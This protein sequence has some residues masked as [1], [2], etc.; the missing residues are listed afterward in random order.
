M[1]AQ[2]HFFHE[3]IWSIL[4]IVL[5]MSASTALACTRILWNTNGV[6]TVAGRTMDWAESTE[7]RLHVFP[8]GMHRNGGRVGPLDLGDENPLTWMSRYGS[9]VVSA[10][11]LASVDGLNEKGLAM[12]LLFLTA[13]DYGPRNPEKAGLQAGLW[14]QYLLDNAATVEEALERMKDVQPIMV[15]HAGFKSSLHL[16][17][18]DASG[19]SAIIEYVDGQPKIYHG[20]EHQVVTNDPPYDEQLIELEKWDFANATR[21]TPLP[22]NVNPIDRF[23]RANYF[24]KTL[25][26]P[27][28]E[29]EAIATTLS[30]ARNASVPFNA[31]YKTPGTIYDTEY[32]TVVNLDSRRFFFELTT[33]PNVIWVNLEDLALSPGSPVLTLNPDNIHL[34]GNVNK[35]FTPVAEPP[36]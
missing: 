21:Q 30:L 35:D 19:D 4:A 33:S 6:L 2:Q 32:R 26:K 20:S 22:G 10:Y 9:V 16:A 34:S 7:P 18:E 12:H 27:E 11:G 17:I 8:R 24:L 25:R 3:S 31:P 23:V 28:G 15:E 29:R 1:V 13:T 5:A 36:F 14:G